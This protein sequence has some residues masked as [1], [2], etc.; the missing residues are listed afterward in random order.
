M[1]LIKH[2]ET[3]EESIKT[4]KE[5]QTASTI[6]PPPGRV[7]QDRQRSYSNQSS[8][9]NSS[10]SSLDNYDGDVSGLTAVPT[11]PNRNEITCSALLDGWMIHGNTYNVKDMIRANGGKW[12]AKF[13]GWVVTDKSSVGRVLKKISIPKKLE[14]IENT[15][16]NLGFTF[17]TPQKKIEEPRV[18]GD[19]EVDNSKDLDDFLGEETNNKEG[20]G[21]KPTGCLIDESDDDSDNSDD[22]V[23]FSEEEE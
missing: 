6:S 23:E 22:N 11:K 14:K 17:Y 2:V 21:M 5:Q 20:G 3:L 8:C 18:L 16:Q 19:N 12:F 9:S 1:A 4:L 13:K 10:V 7:I 15:L